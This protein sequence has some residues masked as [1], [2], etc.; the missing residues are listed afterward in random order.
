MKIKDTLQLGKTGFPMRGNLPTRE[1]E[2]QKEWEDN[3]VYEKRQ[4]LNEGKPSFILHDGPPYANGNIHIGHSLN[5][6]SKDI[7]IRSKSMSGFRAPYVP[8][9]DT[10]G[11]PI[12]QVLTNKGVK[13]KEMSLA[14][15]RKKCQAY[16][17]S[18][19][20]KQ[21]EDFKRLG[22][23]GDWTHPYITL[24]PEYEADQIRVFGK[25]AEKGYIY[26]GMKPIYWSPSSESSLA[27]AEIEYKDVK[28]ASIYVAF[29]VKD[30]K[31]ILTEDT[32]FII[33]TTTPW[34]LPANEGIAVNPDYTYVVVNADG[35]K[36]VVAKDLLET[37]GQAIGWESVEIINEIKGQEMEFMEAQHPFY[38]RTSLVILGDHVTLEAGTGLVHTAP[39][40]GEDD[41]NASR[42]YNLEVLSPVND[43]GIFTD[44]APGFEG[45]FYDK[46]NPMITEL[47]EEK[48]ALL[49]LDFFVHSYPHDWRTKKPVIFRA[50]P[51][52]FASID[53]FRQNILDEVEKVDWIIPWGKTRLYNMIRDRGDWVI[54]RQRA[55][56]VPL[57][58]FYAENGEAIIT[59]ETIQ[60][61]ADLFEEHGSTVWFEWDVKELLPAGFTHP[62]SPNGQFTKEKDIM[63]VWFDSGSSHE[64]VL[65][66]R[67][68]LSF[69]ADMYL[70]GSDQY[71]GW[72]NSS[73]TTSVAINGVAPYKAVLSQGFTLDGEGRKM[74]KSLG[75]TILPEKVIKQMGADILRLWVS[76]V[77]YEADVRVSM[78]IL[79]QVSEIYRKI[80]NTMRFLLANTSDFDPKVN[81]VAYADLRS[82]DKYMLVRLNQVI[83]EIREEGYEKY[84]F[85]HIYKTVINFLTVDLSSFYLDFAK[86]VVYIE[87][88]NDH[89]RRC[90]QT[91]FY[92]TAV[93]LT[94]LL[95]PILPHTA[96][97]IWSYLKEEEEYVQLSEFPA[98]QNFPN[99]EE[100]VD[101]WSGFM[102]FRDQVLKA[103]EEARNQKL[104]G[105]SLE[106]QVTIYPN[107]QIRQLLTAVD[108]QI[109]QLLIISP[110]FLRVASVGE[111]VPAEAQQFDDVAILVEKADGQ[112]CDRCRQ[113]RKDVGVDEKLPTLCGHCAE[114]VEENFPEAV[115][116]GF[117]K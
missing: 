72:F 76:S 90:M 28:S 108:T 2:W 89:Q 63:D 45:I 51:Q 96:E 93:A 30:G 5:K 50:T 1:V 81:Q 103:L 60:R 105:K 32:S 26:K 65:R 52:W 66:Q 29:P 82:V 58:I 98:Y 8:G 48:G 25:M 84:N 18:Q 23:A 7:I 44:E 91:V 19:V 54:S 101:I 31:G 36:F 61:V 110:D 68:E 55:W 64:A 99:Q 71:R 56:G 17:L 117:D 62:G 49:K 100:I 92:E 74:S 83:K 13:R 80:R 111:A 78:D 6:I 9:W 27:E 107:E 37:V 79:T 73:I 57:P 86:D 34:T 85:I 33:W 87:A 77:D 88:E 10:H 95:T 69:P 24:Q 14:E 46:A 35:R 94:K 75:N 115:L 20:D 104:I 42:K 38:D 116:A 40:H 102:S 106:A 47:L 41:Y 43:R 53:K 109:A 21:R 11:L 67:P 12:E 112:V 97:E 22:V 59:P 15:Y 70:E 114:I 39:G 4:A 16:A 113:V 3:H